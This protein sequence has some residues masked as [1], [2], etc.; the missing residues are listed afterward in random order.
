[1][2]PRDKRNRAGPPIISMLYM[3]KFE[4][5]HLRKKGT[6]YSN[7]GTV[8]ISVLGIRTKE[9]TKTA[10]MKIK[11]N[12]ERVT[13]WLIRNEILQN[14]SRGR[15]WFFPLLPSLLGRGESCF[16]VPGHFGSLDCC[17][18][19]WILA[20]VCSFSCSLF[21]IFWEQSDVNTTG[22]GWRMDIYAEDTTLSLS[23]DWKTMPSLN[24]TLS[25]G[26]SE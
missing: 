12:K 15:C 11:T 18:L 17:Y 23:S 25:L 13:S 9:T 20:K 3:K 10:K 14:F 1:M 19:W 16:F 22:W 2:N 6:L 21:V 24:Q 26:L 4:Q 5:G 7:I 8:F